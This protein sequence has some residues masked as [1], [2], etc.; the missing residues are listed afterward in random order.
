MG[1][2]INPEWILIAVI[3]L[4]SVLK[5]VSMTKKAKSIL[6]TAEWSLK[7]RSIWDQVFNQFYW[8]KEFI[9][10]IAESILTAV[11]CSYDRFRTS[12]MVHIVPRWVKP[13][14][15]IFLR[16]A[17]IQF[18][19]TRNQI[20]HFGHR[21]VDP[22]AEFSL[23]SVLKSVLTIWDQFGCLKELYL[24]SNAPR[25]QFLNRDPAE[26]RFKFSFEDSR[27]QIVHLG[28]H[29]EVNPTAVIQLYRFSGQFWRQ[30]WSDGS[31]QLRYVGMAKRTKY[32]TFFCTG[33]N[34]R[35]SDTLE[36]NLFY[37]TTP[38]QPDSLSSVL[39]V[40]RAYILVHHNVSS[41]D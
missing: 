2:Q 12:Q 23:R 33:V 9:F 21:G 40:E 20:V 19:C 1:T 24:F 30:F 31:G 14:A 37:S 38:S 10:S 17:L 16:S 4:R 36:Q 5:A 13:E 3:Y 7:Q 25:R 32:C 6:C 27:N 41:D 39:L 29:C 35:N 22:T 11:I 18:Q 34:P 28:Y 8:S 15:L 26:I